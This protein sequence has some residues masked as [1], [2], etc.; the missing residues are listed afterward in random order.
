VKNLLIFVSLFAGHQYSN[1]E[2][3]KLTF[4]GFVAFCL[5]ASATYVVNDILDLRSDQ[6]HPTKKTRPLAAGQIQIPHA[7]VI[8]LIL[9]IVGVGLGRLVGAEFFVCLVG[10]LVLNFGYSLVF[11]P[12]LA[13]DVVVL[14]LLYILRIV[15]GAAA[16]NVMPS[17]W[18]LAFSLFIFTSLAMLKRYAELEQQQLT[19]STNYRRAYRVEDKSL[20]AMMG[21][22]TGLISVFVFAFYLNSIEVTVLY[23]QAEI[24]WLVIP[25]LFCWII[26][27]WLLASRAMINEDPIVFALSDS[28]SYACAAITILLVML[29]K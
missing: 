24:L 16:T 27:I 17:F 23:Q 5:V 4:I 11:K 2:Y 14:S 6:Q 28:F 19:G 18:L 22:A 25:V 26:R 10:Y 8:A 7:I 21:A 9:T 29:A 3:L 12:M 1:L 13:I 20:M 15:A